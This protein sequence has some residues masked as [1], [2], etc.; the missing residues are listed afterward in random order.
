LQVVARL[1]GDGQTH[2]RRRYVRSIAAAAA[3]TILLA[4]VLHSTTNVNLLTHVADSQTHHSQKH[5]SSRSESR[6]AARVVQKD[7]KDLSA[8][9]DTNGM[10]ATVQY[11]GMDT[12]RNELP[13]VWNHW[14]AQLR[15][16]GSRWIDR[17]QVVGVD[18]DWMGGF[19]GGLKPLANSMS[20]ALHVLRAT[21]VID[22]EKDNPSESPQVRSIQTSA[23]GRIA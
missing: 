7:I 10:T 6:Q 2:G 14:H 1:R 11:D 16:V 9:K 4:A 8:V 22:G 23:T 5:Q 19:A 13:E 17:Q 12:P 18:R 20:S 3:A 21:I 15:T